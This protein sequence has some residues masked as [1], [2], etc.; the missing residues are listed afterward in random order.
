MNSVD[1]AMTFGLLSR[2]VGRHAR[3]GVAMLVLGCATDAVSA[4]TASSHLP[5]IVRQ[6]YAPRTETREALDRRVRNAIDASLQW[7]EKHQ[8]RDGRW[9]CDQFMKHDSVEPVCDGPGNAVHDV[10]V[11]GLALLCFLADGATAHAGDFRQ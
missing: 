1:K 3:V 11:T 10:G 2:L 5:E 9:D 8:D 6:R 4:Q 7:L